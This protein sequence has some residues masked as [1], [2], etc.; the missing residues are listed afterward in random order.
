[1]PGVS[2]EF[3]LISD[4]IYY[5]LFDSKNMIDFT[6]YPWYIKMIKS[7]ELLKDISAKN[8]TSKIK[9]LLNELR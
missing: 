7:N 9:G 4:D 2:N 6:R 5:A 8:A 1:L 3:D